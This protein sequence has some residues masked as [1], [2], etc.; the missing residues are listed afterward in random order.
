MVTNK[1]PKNAENFHCELCDFKCSKKSNYDAHCLTAKHKMVTNGDKNGDKK[2]RKMPEHL[3]CECGKSYKHRQGLSRHKKKCRKTP[4]ENILEEETN[5][6]VNSNNEKKLL[7]IIEKQQ[8][9]INQL[10]P[11]VGNNNNN[12]TTNNFNVNFFLNNDCK[13]A[14]NITD[15]IESLQVQLKDLEYTTDNGH[16]LG[17]TNIFHTALANMEENKR[18]MHCTDLKREVL[19]IK[20]NNEWHKDEDKDIL[21]NAVTKVVDKNCENQMEWLD[22]HP[23]VLVPGSKDS[24]KYIKM[25]SESLGEGTDTEQHKIMKNIMKEVKIETK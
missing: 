13:D 11:C 18:P 24:N 7:E 10:I 1:M 19:Y 4:E 3:T 8:Q 6:P 16:I 12:N 17:I 20:D 22:N 23:D 2:C 21:K 14:M 9:Q 25:M 5:T 15:F